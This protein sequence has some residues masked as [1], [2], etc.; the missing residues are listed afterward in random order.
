MKF[1][2]PK[3]TY[4]CAN[5]ASE[6]LEMTVLKLKTAKALN[7]TTSLPMS[8]FVFLDIAGPIMETV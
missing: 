1:W 5:R 3:I 7:N 8:A 6:G 4:V 2:T